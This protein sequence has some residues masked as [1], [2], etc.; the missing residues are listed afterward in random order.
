MVMTVPILACLDL[1]GRWLFGRLMA[2]LERWHY[3][4][5]CAAQ[6]REAVAGPLLH[7]LLENRNQ[8]A[9][10]LLSALSVLN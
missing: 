1:F 6:R 4:V 3:A 2:G 7:H 8:S 9:G 10:I 5:A